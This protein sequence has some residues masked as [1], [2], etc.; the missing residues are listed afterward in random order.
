MLSPAVGAKIMP[1]VGESYLGN[2]RRE[3]FFS[4]SRGVCVEDTHGVRW[5][6]VLRHGSDTLPSRRG[7][8]GALL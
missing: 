3:I 7:W 2:R 1:K 5:L 4:S 6:V 8:S